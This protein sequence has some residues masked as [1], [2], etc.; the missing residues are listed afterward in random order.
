LHIVQPTLFR[1]SVGLLSY[2]FCTL[3][4]GYYQL[5][6]RRHPCRQVNY[7][8]TELLLRK[9]ITQTVI[10]IMAT[11]SVAAQTTEVGVLGKLDRYWEIFVGSVLAAN[12]TLTTL[13]VNCD[14]RLTDLCSTYA[15]FPFYL[16][17]GPT[18]QGLSQTP[19]SVS[20][21]PDGVYMAGST[22]LCEITSST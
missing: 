10:F 18:T 6:L 20:S 11:T 15:G 16:T 13:E 21:G 12:G 17:L 22:E 4:S 14:P 5:Y 19:T 7:L 3:S 2:A 1:K 9:E 8:P